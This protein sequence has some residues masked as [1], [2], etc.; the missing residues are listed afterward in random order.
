MAEGPK[1]PVST[2]PTFKGTARPKDDPYAAKK[3]PNS[4][5]NK[6]NGSVKS[7]KSKPSSQKEDPNPVVK[8]KIQPKAN[9]KPI[10][11]KKVEPK[12]PEPKKP[13]IKK[14]TIYSINLDFVVASKPDSK[15]SDKKIEIVKEQKKDDSYEEEIADDFEQASDH[16]D[17]DKDKP[18]VI[19]KVEQKVEPK[20]V[21]K[22]ATKVEPMTEPKVESK[23]EPKIVTK[24][25][26]K[27]EPKVAT[28]V[29]PKAE[30]KA[31]IKVEPKAEPKAEQP[32]VVVKVEQ[33][34]AEV[35]AEETK[36]VKPLEVAPLVAD[37]LKGT[38]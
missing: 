26:S 7:I 17:I 29:E 23:A 25:E 36:F 5:T 34:I 22:V 30:P 38:Y 28:K 4:N 1:Q 31:F 19:P 13:E 9:V 12:K 14:G 16:D 20:V 35:K 21:P 8:S 33:P 15:Q 32:I 2:K 37:D 10:A 3:T 6:G 11:P 24:V 18:K 27:A